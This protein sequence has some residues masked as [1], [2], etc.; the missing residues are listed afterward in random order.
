MGLKN[1]VKKVIRKMFYIFKEK[2]VVPIVVPTY[3]RQVLK[4][5]IALVVGGSGGIGLA[6]AETFLKAGA[7][8]VITGTNIEKLEKCKKY[9]NSSNLEIMVLNVSDINSFDEKIKKSADFFGSECIDILVNCAGVIN[10]NDFL[11]ITS[12]E[13]D[14]IM[15]VNV[16]GTFFMCQAVIKLMIENKIR[17]NI[18]N[19]TS[20]SALRPAWT[21]YQMSKW[22]VR[23]FT[24]GL[25]DLF[26]KYGIVVNAIGPGQTATEMAGK[27]IGDTIY[28]ITNPTE[29]FIMPEE[30]ANLA[31]FLVSDMGKMVIGDTVYMTGGSGITTMHN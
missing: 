6:I 29:R 28:N 15:D 21:P 12:E 14:S 31:V 9:I 16:K 30:I 19:I 26:T 13:Y 5:R 24:I 1:K 10:K 7:K 27:K 18:L 22:A 25:A 17:G 23:G 11:N 3:E 20:S 8:V 4:S 2:N